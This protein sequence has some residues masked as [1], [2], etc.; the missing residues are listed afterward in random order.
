MAS[1][2]ASGVEIEEVCCVH[3]YNDYYIFPNSIEIEDLLLQ[4]YILSTDRLPSVFETYN[5]NVVVP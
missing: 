1:L 5:L 4:Y 3:I 2:H